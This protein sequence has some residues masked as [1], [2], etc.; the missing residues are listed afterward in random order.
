MRTLDEVIEAIGRCWS[1]NCFDC[2]YHEKKHVESC[3]RKRDTDALHYLKEY[4]DYREK[5]E[6]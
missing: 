2:P 6:E 3:T 5:V 1:D 4:R